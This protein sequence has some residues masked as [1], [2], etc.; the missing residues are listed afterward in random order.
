MILQVT[1]EMKEGYYLYIEAERG[2]LVFRSRL[3]MYEEGGKTFPYDTEPEVPA[4]KPEDG[5]CCPE[6]ITEGSIGTAYVNREAALSFR[7]QDLPSRNVGLFSFGC[8]D[9]TDF[10]MFRQPN[11]YPGEGE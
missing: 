5:I 4:R 10:R 11:G 9:F 3:R 1:E 7:M 8:S 6:I 2:R